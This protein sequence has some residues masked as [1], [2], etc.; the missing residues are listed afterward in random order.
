VSKII[1]AFDPHGSMTVEQA[2]G[3]AKDLQDVLILGHDQE[4]N[5]VILSSKISNAETIWLI[6]VAKKQILDF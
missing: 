3:C 1:E 6:E 5:L 4:G 2:L